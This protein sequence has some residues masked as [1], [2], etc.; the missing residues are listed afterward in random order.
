MKKKMFKSP[1]QRHL[2]RLTMM[3]FLN[4]IQF[5]E[6]IFCFIY[7]NNF[8]LFL[9]ETRFG[10][11]IFCLIDFRTKR[12]AAEILFKPNIFGLFVAVL[13]TP[14]TMPTMCCF[15]DQF[16][17]SESIQP[18]RETIFGHVAKRLYG[19]RKR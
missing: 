8:F 4:K 10:K 13:K 9:N 1:R 7:L 17:T 12:F 15:L 14:L 11:N 19:A 18:L 3:R 6:N 2:W 5:D 16:R